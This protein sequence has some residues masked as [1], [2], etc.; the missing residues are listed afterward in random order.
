MSAELAS[1]FWEDYGLERLA[2]YAEESWFVTVSGRRIWIA[3][4]RPQDI[5]IFDMAHALSNIG[6]FGGHSDPLYVVGQHSLIVESIVRVDLGR[7]DLAPHALVHDGPEYGLGDVIRPLKRLL[8]PLYKELEL[9]WA[10]AIETHLC[11]RTLTKAEHAIIKQADMI[12]LATERRDV[13]PAAYAKRDE[14]EWIEDEDGIEPL[15]QKIVPMT[16]REARSA[17]LLRA[18]SLGIREQVYT[19]QAP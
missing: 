16:P 15:A 8:G 6:R 11:L 19:E 14:W 7:P 10:S 3:K 12:A 17:F 1:R 2:R 18:T 9:R 13:C 5:S 4:P